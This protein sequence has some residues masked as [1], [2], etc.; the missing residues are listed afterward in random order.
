MKQ[1][2]ILFVCLFCSMLTMA[3]TTESITINGASSEGFITNISFSGNDAMV[4][5]ENGTQQTIDIAALNID[6]D[7]TALLSD[8]NETQNQVML[9]TFGGKTVRVE[10]T[11]TIVGG[12]W[13]TLCLPF[14]MTEAQIATVFGAGTQ[15]AKFNGVENE[16]ADFT[17]VNTIVAGIPYLI[18]P[19]TT[20]STIALDD[21]NLKNLTAGGSMSTTDYSFIGTMAT[22]V[23]TGDIYYFDQDN[24]VKKL[25]NGESVK[26][27]RAYLTSNGSDIKAF[28]I[29]GEMIGNLLGDVNGDTLVN[30]TDVVL[31]VDYILERENPAF[32][33]ENADINS[34]DSINISDVT[35]LVN[36]IMSRQ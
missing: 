17:K 24:K 16:V 13:N 9:N 32:I 20:V 29:D 27:F 31:L 36:I 3:Q 6:F 7:Y 18:N 8:A 22:V 30:I 21:I 23:P 25:A 4:T 1:I 2:S 28:T 26:A 35:E 15:V 10:L 11:R 5:Y 34:D 19:T 12:K 33:I 14:Y